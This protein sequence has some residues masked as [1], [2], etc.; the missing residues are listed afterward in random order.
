MKRII[1]TLFLL[2]IVATPAFAADRSSTVQG[3]IQSSLSN[4]LPK[5]D[6]LVI[7]NRLDELESGTAAPVDGFVRPLPGLSVGVDA[8]GQV[9]NKDATGTDYNGPIVI[10]LMIDPAV[11]NETFEL[12]KKTMPELAGGLR[13]LD[14]FKVVRAVLRQPLPPT[15]SAPQVTIQNQPSQEKNAGWTELARQMAAI[16]LLGGIMI[17]FMSRLFDRERS[18]ASSTSGQ[19]HSQ[20]AHQE[21]PKKRESIINFEELD[22]HVVGLFLLKELQERRTSKIATWALQTEPSGQRRILKTLPGWTASFLEQRLSEKDVLKSAKAESA[23]SVYREIAV[24]E[25]NLHTDVDRKRAFLAWFPAPSLRLVPRHQLSSISLSTKRTLMRIR[26]DLGNLVRVDD[27]D[28]ESSNA[29]PTSE[30]VIATWSELETWKSRHVVPDR[31]LQQDAVTRLAN[32]INS[33]TEFGPISQQLEQ[34]KSRLSAID[35]ARLENEVVAVSTP[36]RWDL[37]RVKSWLR[38]VDPQDY[39]WWLSCCA[40]T[41]KWDFTTMLRPLRR[42]M[43]ERAASEPLYMSW[44]ENAKKEA[45]VRLLQQLRSIHLESETKPDAEAS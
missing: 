8:N 26:Q 19:H 38:V 39:Q 17:W 45:A 20:A 6:Y 18:P 16:L 37:D 30:E 2:T 23:S 32:V 42:A 1:A 33:L 44:T 34:A 41:P 21:E 40:Q 43:F 10:S 35:F 7:V 3:R 9:V 14:E 22:P 11:K 24:L 15:N 27:I 29:E 5:S 36:L 4:V 25:Q 31:D 28:L 12:I 13:D